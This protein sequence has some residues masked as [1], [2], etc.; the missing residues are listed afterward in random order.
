MDCSLSAIA[1]SPG[2][3][4]V[5]SAHTKED[6]DILKKN[7]TPTFWKDVRCGDII[8]LQDGENLPADVLFLMSSEENGECFVQTSSL[9]GERAL[10]NK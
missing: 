1:N 9:D 3:E 2:R 6:L 10:K 8:L 5:K 4:S 7:F